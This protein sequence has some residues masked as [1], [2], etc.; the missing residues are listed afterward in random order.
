MHAM[1]AQQMVLILR[2]LASQIGT[3]ELA[4]LRVLPGD[5]VAWSSFPATPACTMPGIDVGQ[6]TDTRFSLADSKQG[7][8]MQSFP[9]GHVDLH[10]DESDAC[11]GPI[12]HLAA[13]TKLVEGAALGA[14]IGLVAA[15]LTGGRAAALI[16]AGAGLGAAFGAATPAKARRVFR[17]RDLLPTFR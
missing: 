1:T 16:P 7:L 5:A 10:L 12:E 3:D 15:A 13:D 9:E 6:K 2:Q 4:V 17:L 8:H 14:F 11:R